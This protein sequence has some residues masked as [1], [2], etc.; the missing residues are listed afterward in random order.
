MAVQSNLHKLVDLAKEKSSER[1]RELLREVTDLFF[2]DVPRQGSSEL[3]QYDGVLSR[4]AEDTAEDARA[5]LA[6]R[7]ADAP[8]APHG[9]VMQLARDVIEVAAPILR[10]SRALS[11]EDLL[12]IAENTSQSH[13]KALTAR[14]TVPEAVADTIV[15]RGNDDTVVSLVRNSGARISRAAFENIT[16]R[17]E[18]NPDLHAP[19][20]ERKEMPTDL[21]N[22]ML[23]VV[24]SRLRDQILQKFDG[25]DPDELQQAIDASHARLESRLSNDKDADEAKRYVNAMKLRRQLDGALLVRLLREGHIMRC[26]AGL[27]IMTDTDLGTAKR[28]LESPSIDPLCLLCKAGGLDRTLFVT[29]SVMRNAGKGDALRDAREYGRI[30]D[31]LSEREAQRAMRFMTMRKNA[32]AA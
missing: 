16:E 5:E 23:T 3:A 2:D 20:V 30:F 8:E 24:E 18:T 17:A 14:P 22:D 21:L 19:L 1:R 15:R 4:L 6:T 31:E 7:F 32:S 28:A 13:L 27:S 9:L 10:K 25:I 12:T 11:E 29:L 26:A